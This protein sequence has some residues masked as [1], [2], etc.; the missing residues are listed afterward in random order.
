MGTPE[1]APESLVTAASVI[2]L[3]VAAFLTLWLVVRAAIRS[4][5][6]AERR[7]EMGRSP[8][9]G[10]A[11]ASATWSQSPAPQPAPPPDASLG[12]L[13]PPISHTAVPISPAPVGYVMSEP[14]PQGPAFAIGAAPPVSELNQHAPRPSAAADAAPMIAPSPA[15][16][17]PSSTQTPD[18]ARRAFEKLSGAPAAPNTPNPPASE[19]TA[20][21]PARAPGRHA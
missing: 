8:S 16:A 14:I 19:E 3:V 5:L 6:R 21:P 2:G 7:R 15:R 17:A 4:E 13:P 11:P 20:I 12:E 10:P 18:L 1:L 9:T